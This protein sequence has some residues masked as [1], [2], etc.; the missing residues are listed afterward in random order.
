MKQWRCS[1]CN[2]IHEGEEPPEQCPVCG[3]DKDK[4]VAIEDES[5]QAVHETV[6]KDV[7]STPA[8]AAERLTAQILDNHLHPI[9]V[10]GPNGIIPMV[11]LFVAIAV[12][13]QVESFGSA[14]Y[15]SMIFVLLSMPPV[16]FSGYVTWKE[17]YNGKMSPLFKKKIAASAVATFL[18]CA[19]VLW[20]T[21]RP[22]ILSDAS[23]DRFIFLFWSVVLLGA[24]GLAGHLGG[25]LVFGVNKK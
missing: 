4:F 3:A 23:L 9:S 13:L 1:V 20:K 22:D 24:V 17:K 7:V 25:Q 12:V 8:T 19:L 2:Y 5:G 6:Q 16:L 15:L 21:V 18:L 10:H 14:A 11:V